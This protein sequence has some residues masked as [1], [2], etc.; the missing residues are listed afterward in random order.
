MY[1]S[2]STR[3]R[4]RGDCSPRA[5]PRQP[6]PLSLYIR[7]R[8]AR[9]RALG[10]HCS[11]FL[12]RV[13]SLFRDAFRSRRVRNTIHENVVYRVYRYIHGLKNSIHDT[14]TIILG[15]QYTIVVQQNFINFSNNF[16]KNFLKF[17]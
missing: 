9:A 17:S 16:C 1:A 8:A 6:L 15:V 3:C 5:T 12:Y 4:A 2:Y 7:E 11:C 14:Y 13:A 10:C